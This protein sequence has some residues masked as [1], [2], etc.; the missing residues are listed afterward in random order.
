MIE[1]YENLPSFFA[2]STRTTM[3]DHDHKEQ[4]QSAERAVS[5]YDART[6]ADQRD[7]MAQ[8]AFEA[9]ARGEAVD[10]VPMNVEISERS[11]AASEATGDPNPTAQTSGQDDQQAQAVRN[12][13]QTDA[14]PSDKVML[15]QVKSSIRHEIDIVKKDIHRLQK[16]AIPNA[17][18]LT[19][20]V[21]MLRKLRELLADIAHRTIEYIRHLWTEIHQGKNI[22]D[23]LV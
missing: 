3:S 5:K 2:E 4:Q 18:E 23:C 13:L 1:F 17:Y 16:S 6:I 19:K 11:E 20:A 15:R 8:A 10:H 22:R 7:K 14:P 12:R 21:D 9:Q